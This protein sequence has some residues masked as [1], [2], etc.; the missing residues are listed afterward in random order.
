MISLRSRGGRCGGFRLGAGTALLLLLAASPIAS[1]AQGFGPDPFRP[2]NSQYDSY[3]YPIS[4]GPLDPVGNPTLNGGGVRGAN[5]FGNYLNSMDSGNVGTRFDQLYRSQINAHRRPFN[6][7]QAADAKFEEQ[8]SSTTDLYF[9]FIRERDPAKRAALLKAYNKARSEATRG[10]S[11]AGRGAA[12][13]QARKPKGAA[14]A[15]AEAAAPADEEDAMAEGPVADEPERIVTPPRRTGRGTGAA[16]GSRTRAG[17]EAPPA[18][19]I[20]GLSTPSTRRGRTG[21][22]KP[23]DV[24]DRAI[25]GQRGS[26]DAPPRRRADRS[27]PPPPPISP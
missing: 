23:S 6:P 24:L 10:L 13:R 4:P 11:G 17:A 25:R 22:S 9:K 21:D 5:Q 12:E 19:P 7:A 26:S 27:I 15:G 20:S 16:S 14:A 3:V 2:F 18:P 8:Q 1:L